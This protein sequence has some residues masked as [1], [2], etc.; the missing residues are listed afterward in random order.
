M[1]TMEFS[2]TF[3]FIVTAMCDSVDKEISYD[4]HEA[5]SIKFNFYYASSL[6]FLEES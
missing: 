5:N 1:K 2:N 4:I 3:Q 6:F